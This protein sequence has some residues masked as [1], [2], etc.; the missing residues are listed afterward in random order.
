MTRRHKGLTCLSLPDFPVWHGFFARTG[1]RSTEPYH[2]FNT[3]WLTEDDQASANR[4]TLFRTM[5]IDHQPIRI[6]NPCHGERIVFMEDAEWQT[7]KRDV[8]IRTD[9]AF[10]HTPGTYLIF[11]TADCIPGLI[12]DAS[13]S[14]AGLVHLGWRNVVDDFTEKVIASLGTR[15][16]QSPSSLRVAIGP[17]IGACC[18]VFTEPEQ[19][20]DPF[21]KPFLRKQGEG[22]Y[23]IDLASAFKAQLMGCGVLREHILEAGICTGCR[24]D[25]FFSCYKEGYRSGR[26]PVLM[27]LK[28]QM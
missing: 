7:Q 16:H 11:S 26:F 19:A 6:L 8:L 1:G 17:M 3:A 5:G 24:N 27:G 20:D 10:T 4:E 15:Y 18:Y 21:W 25:L 2:S 22:Q 23:A 13:A 14:F 28:L 12:T 9:A